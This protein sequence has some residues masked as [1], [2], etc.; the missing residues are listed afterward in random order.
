[1]VV[2]S[3]AVVLVMRPLML[4]WYLALRLYEKAAPWLKPDMELAVV[5]DQYDEPSLIW[6][7][8][9][10]MRGFETQLDSANARDWMGRPGPRVCILPADEMGKAFPK[11]DPAWRVVMAPELK[12]MGPAV[13]QAAVIKM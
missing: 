13:E 9:K 3:L 1:M 10:E 8:R 6:L 7:F 5:G 4:D 2:L 12:A 11:P